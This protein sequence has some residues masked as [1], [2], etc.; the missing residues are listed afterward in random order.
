MG[1]I[2]KTKLPDYDVGAPAVDNPIQEPEGVKIGASSQESS[3]DKAKK[4]KK[5]LKIAKDTNTSSTTGLN[6]V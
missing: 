5:A 4:G 2:F 6:N 3:E 1:S